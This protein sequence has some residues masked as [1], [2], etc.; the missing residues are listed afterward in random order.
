MKIFG[1]PVHSMLIHF[2]SALFP[3]DFLASCIGFYTHDVH[4]VFTGFYAMC[5]GVAMGILVLISGVTE[6]I[7]VLK[8]N[9]TL[10]SK[11]LIHGALNTLVMIVYLIFVLKAYKSYPGLTID[12]EGLLI[13]KLLVLLFMFFANY[14]GG[15]LIFIHKVRVD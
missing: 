1:H 8:N 4:F 6:L 9:A 14:I 5:L 13:L 7:Y 3:M 10:V 12:S 11:V 2:P 15:S